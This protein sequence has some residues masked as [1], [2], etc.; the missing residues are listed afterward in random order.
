[1][2]TES[3]D[4]AIKILIV[5]D[6]SEI[7]DSIADFFVDEGFQV[8]T[9]ANGEDAMRVLRDEALV[10]PDVII[11]DLLMPVLS[12]VDAYAQMQA[13]PRLCG[14]PV[15]VATSDPS[16]AP[17]GTVTF[18]KPTRLDRLLGA[19]EQACRQ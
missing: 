9:A 17:V 15:I 3:D 16:R 11:L 6:E 8:T 18:R 19:V 4:D 14:V 13:D 5:D 1:M 12:G 10:L 7:R 2:T